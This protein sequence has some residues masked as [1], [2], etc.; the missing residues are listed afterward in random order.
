MIESGQQLLHK[1]SEDLFHKQTFFCRL[2]IQDIIW[3]QQA[4]LLYIAMHT[5]VFLQDFVQSNLHTHLHLSIE[6]EIRAGTAP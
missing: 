3:N 6:V 2:F 5:D 1:P 4:C